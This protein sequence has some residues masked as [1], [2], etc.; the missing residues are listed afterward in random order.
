MPFHRSSF[1]HF[2]SSSCSFII[3]T[4]PPLWSCHFESDPRPCSPCYLFRYRLATITA[5]STTAGEPLGGAPP[6]DGRPSRQIS[7]E[8][9]NY[10]YLTVLVSPVSARIDCGVVSAPRWAGPPSGL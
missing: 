8:W 6:S 9:W 7:L 5:C 1:V 10:A 2:V 4:S 3:A